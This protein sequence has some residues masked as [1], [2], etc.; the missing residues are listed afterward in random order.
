MKRL[1]IVG[2]IVLVALCGVLAASAA[3]A[4]TSAK[5]PSGTLDVFWLNELGGMATMVKNFN[6]VYPNV[7]VNLEIVPFAQYPAASSDSGS[8]RTTRPT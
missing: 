8:R 2:S 5:S 4:K 7:K 6:N 1:A 3:S